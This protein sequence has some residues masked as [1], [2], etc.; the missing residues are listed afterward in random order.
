MGGIWEGISK[1]QG[2]EVVK[3]HFCKKPMCK[4]CRKRKVRYRELG[5]NRTC[6]VRVCGWKC[7]QELAKSGRVEVC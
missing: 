1:V 3:C 5:T 7:A 4:F 2:G 6:I